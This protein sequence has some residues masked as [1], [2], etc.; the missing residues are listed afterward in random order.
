MLNGSAASRRDSRAHRYP[1]QSR[2]S[3]PWGSQQHWEKK[4]VITRTTKACLFLVGRNWVW[5][6]MYYVRGKKSRTKGHVKMHKL[7]DTWSRLTEGDVVVEFTSNKSL[8]HRH[9][10]KPSR[11]QCRRT[12]L[13]KSGPGWV[14]LTLGT[15][16]TLESCLAWRL[17]LKYAVQERA[18]SIYI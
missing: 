10:N 3:T 15:Q 1:T 8:K 17:I 6:A 5:E 7:L 18:L 2:C 12:P 16:A 13:V 11:D 9:R 4:A 14:S